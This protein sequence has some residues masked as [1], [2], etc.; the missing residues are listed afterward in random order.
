MELKYITLILLSFLIGLLVAGL[1]LVIM[2]EN[3]QKAFDDY[4]INAN[5]SFNTI[6]AMNLNDQAVFQ[7]KY[8]ALLIEKNK[9]V[10][11]NELMISTLWD[12][13]KNPLVITIIEE[14]SHASS[15]STHTSNDDDCEPCPQLQRC[16]PGK[17][18][19]SDGEDECGCA[20]NPRCVSTSN[21]K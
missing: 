6:K 17:T 21:I 4:R 12:L 19:E 3:T 5:Q 18:M 2:N 1:P 14:R 11:E 7:A 15:S 10:E 16:P 9:L 8:N 13:V 20:I